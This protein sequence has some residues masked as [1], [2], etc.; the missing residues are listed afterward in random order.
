M[1]DDKILVCDVD[2]V[3]VDLSYEWFT[4]LRRIVKDKVFTYEDLA[5]GYDFTK[6]LEGLITKEE[7]FHF[8][9]RDNLYDGKQPLPFAADT[10]WDL[11]RNHGFNI[12]FA[13]HVEGNHAKSKYEFLKKHFPVDGFMATREKQF[14]RADIAIDDRYEHLVDHPQTV[15]KILKYTPH[16]QTCT[17]P[18]KPD[19]VLYEWGEPATQVI[20]DV[21]KRK[22]VIFR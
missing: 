19:G 3:V 10:L 11:K 15:G 17:V 16:A 8:W 4:Y 12:I 9:K 14:I 7:A 6:P 5:V 18:F 2:G 13:S 20:L 1:G 22:Q 21:H